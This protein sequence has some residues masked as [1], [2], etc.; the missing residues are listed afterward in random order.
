MRQRQEIQEVPWNKRIVVV[1]SF[2]W[3]QSLTLELFF[4]LE[5]PCGAFSIAGGYWALEAKPLT[6]TGVYMC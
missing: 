4:A 3:L 2:D 6:R 5:Q 1:E